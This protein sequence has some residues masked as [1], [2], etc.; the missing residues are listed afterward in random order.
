MANPVHLTC[1]IL[2]CTHHWEKI[3]V[4]INMVLKYT[5]PKHRMN[6]QIDFE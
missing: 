6:G 2:T 3:S 5:I 1:L 4:G